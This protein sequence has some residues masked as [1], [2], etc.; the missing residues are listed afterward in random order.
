MV[1]HAVNFV[2]CAVKCI[3][4]PEIWTSKGDRRRSHR[5]SGEDMAGVTATLGEDG[6]ED[7]KMTWLSS[8]SPRGWL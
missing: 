3:Y 7:G 5:E 2:F 8:R 1:Y 6:L 4:D